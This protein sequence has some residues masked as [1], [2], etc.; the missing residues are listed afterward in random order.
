[1]FSD[2]CLKILRVNVGKILIFCSA[3]PTAE[4][5]AAETA[6]AGKNTEAH[7]EGLNTEE[8]ESVSL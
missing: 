2:L 7:H 5:A 6:A 4:T 3:L 1:M 8:R